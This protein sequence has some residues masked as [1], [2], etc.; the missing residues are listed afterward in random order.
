ML[1]RSYQTTFSELTERVPLKGIDI[2]QQDTAQ[3]VGLRCF[4]SYPATLLN[5]N[6]SDRYLEFS[7]SQHGRLG[8]AVPTLHQVNHIKHGQEGQGD[9][10]VA[11]GARTL[12]VQDVAVVGRRG[13]IVV[14]T[15]GYG[16][17]AENGYPTESAP[18]E[19]GKAAIHEESQEEAL[20]VGLPTQGGGQRLLDRPLLWGGRERRDLI[21]RCC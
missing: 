10:D 21:L 17:G 13:G 18:G 20:P 11:T 14:G 15:E 3:S 4:S 5:A 6:T 1:T 8:E 7:M 2:S 16:R 19:C 12:Q 9:V